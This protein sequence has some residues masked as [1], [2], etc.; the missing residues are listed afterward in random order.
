MDVALAYADAGVKVDMV[1]WKRGNCPVWISYPWVMGGKKRLEKLL[2]VRW[3]TWF[4]PCRW[5]GEDGWRWPRKFLHDTAIGRWIV[6]Q[7]WSGLGGEVLQ[8]NGYDS[9]PEL[10]KLEPWNSAFWIGSGLNIHNHPRDFFNMVK[11]GQVGIHIADVERLTERTVHLSDGQE[12]N[13]DVLVCATGWRKEPSFRSS[14]SALLA[15][16]SSRLQRRRS[17][18]LPP[19]TS[20]RYLCTLASKTSPFSTSN[21][22]KPLSVVPLHDPARALPRPQHRLRRHGVVGQHV[23]LRLGPGAV[24]RRVPRQPP[25]PRGRHPGGRHA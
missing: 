7:F 22:Q 4:S 2:T 23:E 9:H 17:S 16:A 1:N 19:P 20:R 3:M 6:N 8:A 14:I 18:S 12:L 24:D 11:E 13:T 5:G 25:G 10:Q 21:P 15:S